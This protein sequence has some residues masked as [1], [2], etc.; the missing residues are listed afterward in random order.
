MSFG[1]LLNA[2][3]DTNPPGVKVNTYWVNAGDVETWPVLKTTTDP[4]DTITYDGDIVLKANKSFSKIVLVTDTGEVKSNLVGIVGSK[5]FER[6]L[7]GTTPKSGP[8]QL[9]FYNRVANACP[10]VLVEDKNGNMHVIGSPD[11]PAEIVTAESGTGKAVG[12]LNGT[13]F[14]I[15]GTEGAAGYFYEGVIDE[16]PAT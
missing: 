7:D 13:A 12:D 2:C 11:V 6:T 9:E 8:E 3:G 1:D 4:G 5:S 10:I 14:S 16:D 15:K